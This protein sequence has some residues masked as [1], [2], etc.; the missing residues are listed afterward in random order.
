MQRELSEIEEGQDRVVK[1]WRPGKWLAHFLSA[2]C[3]HQ[4]SLPLEWLLDQAGFSLSSGWTS[5][6]FFLAKKIR[7]SGPGR[8][9]GLPAA[10]R[11]ICTLWWLPLPHLCQ[12]SIC[13][14]CIVHI[15]HICTQLW[16]LCTLCTLC[17]AP[18]QVMQTADE[19][20]SRYTPPGDIM[21]HFIW[22]LFLVIF[23][24]NFWFYDNFCGRLRILLVGSG[25]ARFELAFRLWRR[26]CSERRIPVE[27]KPST[28]AVQC[29][30]II[31]IIIINTVH[32]NEHCIAQCIISII[33]EKTQV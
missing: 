7:F 1:D 33:I 5:R 12:I 15:V 32:C 3:P 21:C 18:D 27:C 23:P 13:K 25:W 2:S 30:I 4:A 20:M 8:I 26:E 6:S 14:E 19:L 17:S 22:K 29:S 28:I 31:I 16:T 9:F 10:S 24:H 11:S